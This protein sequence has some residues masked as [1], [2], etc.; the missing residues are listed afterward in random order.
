[1]LSPNKQADSAHIES[2]EVAAV[3]VRKTGESAT[4]ARKIN[5]ED[6]TVLAPWYTQLFT[7]TNTRQ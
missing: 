3:K 1:M 2:E 7:S 6:F 4:K 5:T